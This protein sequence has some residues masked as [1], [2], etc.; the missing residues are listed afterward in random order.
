MRK[1]TGSS[2]CGRIELTITIMSGSEP[3]LQN[4]S[5]G[6][7]ARHGP[8]IAIESLRRVPGAVDFTLQLSSC[9]FH[10]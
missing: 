6:G 5:V 3:T 2:I 9:R 1:F 10:E 7:G 4:R 8:S